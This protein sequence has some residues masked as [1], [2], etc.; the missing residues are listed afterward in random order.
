MAG[1]LVNY[2]RFVEVQERRARLIAGLEPPPGSPARPSGP[3]VVDEVIDVG[4][5]PSSIDAGTT[6]GTGDVR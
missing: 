3:L 1:T 5:S 4:E 6:P 2:A